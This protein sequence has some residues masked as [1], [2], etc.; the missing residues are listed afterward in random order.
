LEY[1]NKELKES[2]RL[3]R[4]K[5]A[6]SQSETALP[7]QQFTPNQPTTQGV[8]Q[9]HD[10]VFK[11]QQEL[12]SDKFKFM[13]EKM[14]NMEEKLNQ[15]PR[16]PQHQP[17]QAWGENRQIPYDIHGEEILLQLKYVDAQ[18][19]IIQRQLPHTKLMN[20][21]DERL[22]SLESLLASHNA[23]NPSSRR[24]ST[25]HTGGST[26]PSTAAPAATQ[27]TDTGYRPTVG[28]TAEGNPP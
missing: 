21:I 1:E 9:Y 10:T 18:L 22:Q 6:T 25:N 14:K 13:E 2:T 7:G 4:L 3:L 5:L 24:G 26:R 23:H 16:N 27:A 11:L 8:N 15:I 28:T 19:G 17:H 12:M 20:R